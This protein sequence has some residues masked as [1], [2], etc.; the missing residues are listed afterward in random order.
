MFPGTGGDSGGEDEGRAERRRTAWILG[1]LAELVVL[2]WVSQMAW[3]T[4]SVDDPAL[5]T[6]DGLVAIALVGAAA[7][8]FIVAGAVA[9]ATGTRGSG[10]VAGAV[11]GFIGG[12]V[13]FVGGLLV[14]LTRVDSGEH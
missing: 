7:S 12:V 14:A 6:G 4:D 10:T 2:W 9:Y 11:L 13:G 1:G 3:S 5:S 8:V